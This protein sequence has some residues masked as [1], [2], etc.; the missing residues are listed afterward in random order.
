M[1]PYRKLPE[2]V[3]A[4]AV[5][6]PLAPALASPP[7]ADVLPPD[8]VAVPPA[9]FA[10]PAELA[11]P[12]AEV[13]VL[14]ARLPELP[15]ALLAPPA[16]PF[17]FE[18]PLPHAVSASEMKKPTEARRLRMKEQY[19]ARASG[20]REIRES[21]NERERWKN[22]RICVLQSASMCG[23]V[24]HAIDRQGPVS[25]LSALDGSPAI[26]SRPLAAAS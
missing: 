25:M 26:P 23:D 24:P 22:A 21:A 16:A 6:V 8:V 3:A 2:P 9:E 12:P 19:T 18:L 15:P 17:E 5:G 7:V 11:E 1:Y 4:P 14:P 10:A 20:R 13:L